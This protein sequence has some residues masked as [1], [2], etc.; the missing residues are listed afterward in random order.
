MTW[1]KQIVHW[2]VS[3]NHGDAEPIVEIMQMLRYLN[4][5]FALD[6]L[7]PPSYGGL[8]WCI[9]WG[10]KP[11]SNGGISKKPAF[12]YKIR[13][14]SFD[15]AAYILMD[16]AS[17]EVGALGGEKKQISIMSSLHSQSRKRKELTSQEVAFVGN[18]SAKTTAKTLDQHFRKV[19]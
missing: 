3:T 5:R 1:G 16:T 14:A 10:D 9:G 12:R 13:A 11:S 7:S 19:E 17:G 15:Q 18:K 2:G 8:L 4:D 6:G